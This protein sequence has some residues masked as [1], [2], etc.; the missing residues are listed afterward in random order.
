MSTKSQRARRR[1]QRIEAEQGQVIHHLPAGSCVLVAGAD[2]TSPAR[3]EMNPAYSGGKLFVSGFGH[4][5][6]VDLRGVTVNKNAT[7]LLD[8]KS[9]QRV[10][11]PE[12]IENDG[13]QLTAT[14]VVSAVNEHAREVVDSHKQG[15]RWQSSIG[16]R[17]LK[18]RSVAEGV[19][20]TANGQVFRGPVILATEAE[21]FEISF[22]GSGGDGQNSVSLAAS[23]NTGV[24]EMTFAEW[25]TTGGFSQ[26]TL[27]DTQ[28]ATLQA[29]FDSKPAEDVVVPVE[30][31]K[32]VPAASPDGTSADTLLADM[33]KT[34]GEESKRISEITK[35]TED[36]PDI[37][38]EAIS[39]GLS[40][41][42]AEVK[43]LRA[44]RDKT[45]KDGGNGVAIHNKSSLSDGKVL[46]AALCMQHGMDEEQT[47]EHY[48]ARIM[49][50]ALS[51]EYMGK[52]S[53]HYLMYETL[54]AAGKS[55]RPGM[56]DVEDFLHADKELRA[57]GGT[58]SSM[59]TQGILSNTANKRLFSS[60]NSVAGLAMTLAEVRPVTDFKAHSAYRL[61]LA[62]DLAEVLNGGEIEHAKATD[63]TFTHA[64]KT[65]G[66]LITLSRHDMINDDLGAFNSIPD[67]LGRK[68]ALRLEKE[69]WT[70]VL[71]N[72]NS[73][74]HAD[75]NNYK[76]GAGSALSVD[77]LSTAEQ[78][79]LDQTDTDDDPVML[80]ARYLV[81]GTALKVT[82]ASLSNEQRIIMQDQSATA[83]TKLTADNPHAGK[84]TPLATPWINA[85]GLTG[86]SATS[87]Y[88]WGDPADVAPF[89]VS[90]L[91]GRRTPTISSSDVDFDRLGMSFRVVYDFGVDQAD[92]K[93]VVLSAGV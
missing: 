5:V 83:D 78:T 29:A 32:V 31:P 84:W 44:E 63:E 42:E 25:L 52:L 13:K 22:V 16:A 89:V 67:K 2:S 20:V 74:F 92:P 62:G 48:D 34:A 85:Q 36:W 87:H 50:A 77:S 43:V 24:T 90:V 40:I 57:A 55:F 45:E 75:N 27:D 10:G 73:F 39:D 93:A 59:S 80:N 19:T 82:A 53:L 7:I 71:G 11:H 72:A 91:N 28:V 12:N 18:A 17:I 4:P 49:E 66:L 30:P 70:I 81:T 41:V 69:F 58:F 37:R 64:A 68:A 60:F 6:V 47:S 76:T 61:T 65:Y 8:H 15:F 9:S 21:L 38:A 33:R 51:S 1:S 46:E 86:N 88:L 23:L 3:F 26:E 35:I 54:R 14:G 56:I 79:F